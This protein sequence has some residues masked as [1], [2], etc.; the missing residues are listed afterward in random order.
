MK[1]CEE[2][3]ALLDAF[4]DG[5][6]FTE[7]MTYVQ[8]H[9]NECP[10]CQAYLEDLFAIRAAFPSVEDTIVPDGFADSVMAAVA[11]H[12]RTVSVP[13]KRKSTPWAKILAPL[14]ACLALVIILQNDI[15]GGNKAAESASV[16]YD[17][18]APQ[19][20]KSTVTTES[21]L[22]KSSS[23]EPESAAEE[24]SA[25]MMDAPAEAPMEAPAYVFT[26]KPATE[27]SFSVNGAQ[28]K[29]VLSDEPAAG[30]TEGI[31]S[32]YAQTVLPPESRVYL[33]PDKLVAETETELH[34]ALPAQ[35]YRDLLIQL[36][37]HQ[38]FPDEIDLPENE[39]PVDPILVIVQK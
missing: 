21:F 12:P 24:A 15:V 17:A 38:I 19:D 36:E 29:E 37:N 7:D 9:L 10:H 23:A 4:A 20:A 18:A 26:E 22:A 35:E 31:F 16:A 11:A 32:Y 8:Q 2:Y 5:D 6:L 25:S 39:D 1:N 34:Y 28:E 14:A 33:P 27:D 30:R 13:R 3:A